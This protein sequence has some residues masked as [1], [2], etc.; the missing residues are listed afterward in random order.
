MASL[1][2]HQRN[3]LA[4]AKRSMERSMLNIVRRDEIR[5]EV[6]RALTKI[7]DIIGKVETMKGQWAG[8][9]ARMS[10]NRWAKKTTEWTPRKRG[11]QRGG[12]NG[13]RRMVAKMNP[14]AQDRS[15]WKQLRRPLANSGVT[16]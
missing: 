5:N 14:K 13:D 2:K 6:S 9:L 15:T 7:V 16:G 8:H 1:T 11:V 4:V 12:Q 3:E 10:S